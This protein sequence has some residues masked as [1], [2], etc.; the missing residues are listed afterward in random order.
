MVVG[1]DMTKK[2]SIFFK[3]AWISLTIIGVA[4]LIFGLTTIWPESSDSASLHAISVASIGMGLFGI[5]ITITAFRHRERWAW[6]VLWYYP[7]FWIAHFWGHLPPSQDQVHQI[8]F[9]I[10]S[11][12]ALLISVSDFFP[13]VVDRAE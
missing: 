13:R 11:L 9:I 3:I 6:F 5:M 7:I 12:V 2:E 8:V 4:I 1:Q 10:L